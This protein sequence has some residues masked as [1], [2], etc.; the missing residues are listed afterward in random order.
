MAP[1]VAKTASIHDFRMGILSALAADAPHSVST[2][3]I[4]DRVTGGNASIG[5]IALVHEAL[6]ELISDDMISIEAV[7]RDVSLLSEHSVD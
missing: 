1:E 4:I 5:T 2:R 7:T 3:Q 6:R